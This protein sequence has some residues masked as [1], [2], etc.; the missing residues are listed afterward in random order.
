MSEAAFAE[1]PETILQ[2]DFYHHVI[3]SLT[4]KQK[5]LHPKYFYDNTGS[6]YFDQICQLDEYYP[7]RTELALLPDVARSVSEILTDNYSLIEFGAGSLLK[8]KPLLD[9]VAGIKQFIPMDISGEHLRSACEELQAEYPTLDVQPVEA[10]FTQHVD[11]RSGSSLKRLGFFPGS[12]IGNFTP[13]EAQCFLGNAKSTLGDRSYMLVG[14]DTKKS[15]QRLHKAYNDSRG[16]TAAFN[17]NILERINRHFSSGIETSKFEHY[18]YYNTVKGCIEMHLVCL[19]T[20]SVYLDGFRVT[21]NEGES[22][23]TESSYK[24]SPEEF[25]SMAKGSG[26][27]VKQQW[28]AKENMFSIFLLHNSP[29]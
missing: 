27:G 26:W 14:V 8:V 7:Y 19:E 1:V 17:R 12:T 5:T 28:L 29:E 4:K 25:C 6:E 9:Y 24:Y 20:Q 16:V 2:D 21:F 11:L 22:I 18:A 15:P 23:H 3:E 13:D 10:D